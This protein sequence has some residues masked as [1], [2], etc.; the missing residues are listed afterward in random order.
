MYSFITFLDSFHLCL[1]NFAIIL[2]IVAFLG[3]LF[4]STLNV[5]KIKLLLLINNM[6]GFF[7]I[8]FLVEF[9]N[10]TN[11][12]MILSECLW[13]TVSLTTNTLL[14]FNFFGFSI[15]LLF[16]LISILLVIICVSIH[17]YTYDLKRFYVLLSILEICLI[18]IFLTS[19][20]LLFY[21]ILTFNFN[22]LFIKTKI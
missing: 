2:I 5:K 20:I 11:N 14:Q 18:V 22:N 4:I 12:T 16:L 6:L 9:F 13:F 15:S 1:L 10:N 7:F 21:I 3:T 8:L 17:K 19:N